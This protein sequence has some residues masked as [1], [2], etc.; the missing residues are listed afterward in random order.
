MGK[1]NFKN[2]SFFPIENFLSL[3]LSRNTV[4]LRHLLSVFRSTLYREVAYERL[5]TKENNHAFTV[6]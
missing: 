3:V 5:K 2:K 6:R 4:I 1:V